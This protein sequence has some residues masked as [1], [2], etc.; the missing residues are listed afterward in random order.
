MSKLEIVSMVK[1]NGV[2]YRQEEVPK[3]QFKKLLEAKITESMQNL[4]FKRDKVSEPMFENLSAK[5]KTA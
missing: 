3:D 1:I 5:G 4:G 2:W